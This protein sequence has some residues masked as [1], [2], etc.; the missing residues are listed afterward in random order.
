VAAVA[1]ADSCTGEATQGV[2]TTVSTSAGR[3]IMRSRRLLVVTLLGALGI[4][5]LLPSGAQAQ[6]WYSQNYYEPGYAYGTYYAAPAYYPPAY[7]YSAYYA[8]PTYWPSVYASYYYSPRYYAGW[9]GGYSYPP[10]YYG[11]GYPRRS[12]GVGYYRW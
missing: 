1:A 12:Y 7:G 3:F 11:W 10:T 8:T 9:Y 2:A 5:G 6:V 4:L